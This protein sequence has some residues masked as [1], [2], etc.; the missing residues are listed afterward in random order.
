LGSSSN[1]YSGVLYYTCA[2]PLG[3]WSGSI[4]T[5]P[6]LVDGTHIAVT[7]PCRT[8]GN[9]FYAS[10]VDIDGESWANPPS[11]G[12]DEV[13]E[14]GLTGPLSVAIAAAQTEVV[15][16]R[17][18]GLTGWITGRASRLEWAFG[19][20]PAVTNVSYLAAHAWTNTGDYTVT[21]TAFNLDHPAGVSTNLLVHVVP[22]ELPVLA[23][24]GMSSNN[25]QLTFGS[26]AGVYYV[27]EYATNL[28]PPMVWQTLQSRTSTG[29]V[30]AVQD[31]NATN[32]ARFYRVR[33]P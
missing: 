16:N 7:S 23:A 19:D 2:S 33:M 22:L 5:D 24:G 13:W 4:A 3:P 1:Y 15:A 21:F 8:K 6:Q 17:A 14:A 11:M 26:Q 25:Y 32:A 20:G 27:V 12:C 18:L 10:S 29:G 31:S 28:T 30:I 9:A